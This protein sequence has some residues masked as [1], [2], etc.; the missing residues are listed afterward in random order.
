MS[1]IFHW[2]LQITWASGCQSMGCSFHPRAWLEWRWLT[3]RPWQIGLGKIV[4]IKTLGDFRGPMLLYQS[5]TI[6]LPPLPQ[7]KY[8]DVLS[9]G[10]WIYHLVPSETHRVGP[11][12]NRYF[13]S[14]FRL[15]PEK[16]G[17]QEWQLVIQWCTRVD[18]VFIVNRLGQRQPAPL[19]AWKNLRWEPSDY[20]W[21]IYGLV[22][23]N[24]DISWLVDHI[25]MFICLFTCASMQYWYIIYIYSMLCINV[26]VSYIPFHGDYNFLL[27]Q[28]DSAQPEPSA[29]VFETA[30]SSSSRNLNPD[31]ILCLTHTVL[32]MGW[33]Q[34][35]IEK[36][37]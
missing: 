30:P 22:I 19:L 34:P 36:K 23:F 16:S 11:L 33:W 13:W 24:I 18:Q 25:Y 35:K 6:K 20:E 17:K 21:G 1:W 14:I 2:Y 27:N 32:L 28:G 5:V 31:A 29:T 9:H 3:V 10:T 26:W 8:V 15:L 4:S 12:A 37:T 7:K